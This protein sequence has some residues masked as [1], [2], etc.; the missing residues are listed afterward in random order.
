MV[1]NMLISGH[2][3]PQKER[4]ICPAGYPGSKIAV[5]PRIPECSG[6]FGLHVRVFMISP[7]TY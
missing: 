1:I 3:L 5:F 4:V 6:I 7:E 2:F